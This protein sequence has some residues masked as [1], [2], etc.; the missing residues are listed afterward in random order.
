MSITVIAPCGLICDLCS[1]FQRQKN[2]CPGCTAEGIKPLSCSKCIIVNCPEKNGDPTELCN[3]CSKYPCKRLKALNKRYS[4]NY[5]E[6]LFENFR[7]IELLGL[8]HFITEAE[9]FWSCP[10]CGELLSVHH[11]QCTRCKTANI[12]YLRKPKSKP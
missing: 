10:G 8:D 2:R 3:L 7:Q 4:T 6:S 11:P 1:A 5:G 9:T 12:H